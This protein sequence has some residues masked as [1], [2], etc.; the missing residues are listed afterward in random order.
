RS[1]ARLLDVFS[2]Y[3]SLR[4]FA[5]A[6]RAH[7]PS[8]RSCA[9]SHCDP[10]RRA[11]GA[12]AL[13]P[14]HHFGARSCGGIKPVANEDFTMNYLFPAQAGAQLLSLFVYGVIARWYVVPWLKSQTRAD[15]L[16]ALLGPRLPLC[17]SAGVLRAT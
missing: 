14:A 1:T 7:R 2:P 16:I 4:A 13:R 5:I 8:R 9:L 10:Q 17:R 6:N 3:P 12:N 11:A 15:A